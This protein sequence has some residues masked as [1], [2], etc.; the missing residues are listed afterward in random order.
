[1]HSTHHLWYSTA[2]HRG[3][4]VKRLWGLNEV[5]TF[6]FLESSGGMFRR[7]TPR[8]SG[9]ADAHWT[10]CRGLVLQG[11]TGED[12]WMKARFV[13]AGTLQQPNSHLFRRQLELCPDGSIA[14]DDS[15]RTSHH[16][17][18]VYAVGDV[19]SFPLGPQFQQLQHG[20]QPAG[21]LIRSGS[22]H[23]AAEAGSYVADVML[24]AHCEENP[25]FAPLPALS[26]T[27]GNESWCF[28]GVMAGEAVTLGL[29][30]YRP[31][32]RSS[33]TAAPSSGS[34]SSSSPSALAVFW[35]I[36][37]TIVGCYVHCAEVDYF[38]EV[39]RIAAERPGILSI[40]QLKKA[41][42]HDLLADPYM[43]SPPPLGIG[44]FHADHDPCSMNEV[45]K[46]HESSPGKVPTRKL[47]DIMEALGAD[48]DEHELK[49]AL[50]G[51]DPQGQGEV[52]FD[53]FSGWWRG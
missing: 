9:K 29:E 19:C 16:S 26:S 51:L 17:N 15:L 6:P 23:F 38:Q 8:P 25:P 37:S 45:L 22:E 44:E 32:A 52:A 28:A 1:M 41:K 14:T 30:D 43:L 50:K 7:S 34:G 48:W 5:G 40:K 27:F 20:N 42:L 10:T 2:L 35:V 31:T 53:H 24:R 12:A 21:G 4:T 46:E 13:V 11:A 18:N 47:G 33:T 3:Y 39:K 36:H 49:L